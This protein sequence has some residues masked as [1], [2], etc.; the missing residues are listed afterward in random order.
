MPITWCRWEESRA[1]GSLKFLDWI[2]SV[3]DPVS[4]SK[5]GLSDQG[6]ARDI[7]HVYIKKYICNAPSPLHIPAPTHTSQRRKRV[8]LRFFGYINKA[9]SLFSSILLSHC[10]NLFE[11]RWSEGWW[12]PPKAL[13][14][15]VVLKTSCLESIFPQR[16][17]NNPHFPS[18]FPTS[19][20][21]PEET[22]SKQWFLGPWTNM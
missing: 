7:V 18:T 5:A 14:H 9:L 10:F 3:R 16:R 20:N 8:N 19:P 17:T 12:R 15:S 13:W 1:N 6:K 22:T 21:R 11:G 2:S 4:N